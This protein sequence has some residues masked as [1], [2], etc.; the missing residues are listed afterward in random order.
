MREISLKTFFYQ[1]TLSYKITEKLGI[2]LGYIFANGDFSLR[3]GIPIQDS[4]GNYGE[5]TLAGKASGQGFNAGVY[6]KLNDK[7][8][9]PRWFCS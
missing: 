8:Y 3:K 4:L 5:A 9:S 6:Y 2:G 7:N 1:P